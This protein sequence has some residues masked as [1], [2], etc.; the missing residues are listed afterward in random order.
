MS[1]RGKDWWA[2]GT[3]WWDRQEHDM[4]QFLNQ[5]AEPYTPPTRRQKR[6]ML[7]GG[8]AVIGLISTLLTA[9]AATVAA[10]SARAAHTYWDQLEADLPAD[11]V[12]PSYTVLTDIDGKVFA[13][14]YSQ[15]RVPVTLDDISPHFVDAIIATEDARFWDH[16]GLDT[17]GL[18]RAAANNLL[19]GAR[20]GGSTL[21][22]QLVENMRLT[23]ARTEE[24]A[25][26]AKAQ[27]L[28]GKL[29]E[30]KYAV[31]LEERYSKDEILEMYANTVYFGSG[32][33]G[34]Y[35]AAQR[36]FS[37]HPADLTLSQAATLAGLVKNPHGYDPIE[38]PDRAK[39]RRDVV[40][41]RML[42]TGAITPEEH[43]AAVAEELTVEPG[44]F[45]NGCYDSD[46]PLYCAYVQS[47]ILSDPAFGDTPEERSERL[48]LGGM[49]IRTAL[50]RQEIEAAQK[51]VTEA[52]GNDNRVAAAVAIV[53]PGTGYVSALAQNR[54]FGQDDG[55]TEVI[56]ATSRRQTGSAFKPFTLAAAFEAGISPHER[57][58]SS[59]T[60]RPTRVDSPR[61][62]FTNHLGRGYGIQDAYGATRV[63]SNTWFIRLIERIGVRD[64]AELA[65]RLGQGGV[66]QDLT[67]REAAI[68]LGAYD[69]SPLEMAAGYA[70]FASG[71]IY[72][73]P[74]PIVAVADTAT[75]EEL[76]A[77]DPGCRRE[78]MPGVAATVNEV[79]AEPFKT[80]GTAEG[81]GLDVPAGGKTGTSNQWADAWF[82]GYTTTRS[83]AVWMGDPRGS[84][85]TLQGAWAMGRYH[86]S[87]G[88]GTVPAPIWRQV[89]RASDAAQAGKKFPS[90]SASLQTLRSAAAPNVAGMT[91]ESAVAAL[92]DAG[93]R[94]V[95]ADTTSPA[96]RLPAGT[97]A[98]AQVDGDTATLTL[99][100]G[101]PAD[102]LG[103]E[104][105][106][107]EDGHIE[108]HPV[109]GGGGDA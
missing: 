89:M 21:T 12:V 58:S 72:C 77:P 98:S 90:A 104:A 36:Y 23:S 40:L 56:Y 62:G 87:I 8:L 83:A 52:L 99:V 105:H 20:Q 41:G 65:G 57:W 25:A 22:Q 97:V 37:T 10:T 102:A 100:D 82:V 51:A 79:L 91:L 80:G 69:S 103:T 76:P 60:Y 61:G 86:H 49:T 4:R 33:Y 85:H 66:P 39:A 54:E 19:G 24:E 92:L 70:T 59:A 74:T 3:S 96:G 31:A 55:Q 7:A 15:N 30:A 68:T 81:M 28:E 6:H 95:V 5:L 2:A 32:A 75:G 73:R 88:G 38:H 46:Y 63:S 9:P 45:D 48:Y 109:G 107:G 84:T 53:E 67:G 35:T 43:D 18:I 101:A 16:N 34:I 50:D 64:V 108:L 13:Q 27:T 11:G 44:S 29:Q 26:E 1:R 17:R 47:E 78:L 71:G 106:L 94:V 93:L 14:F 42:A